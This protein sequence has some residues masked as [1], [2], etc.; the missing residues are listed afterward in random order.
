[1]R[2]HSAFPGHLRQIGQTHPAEGKNRALQTTFPC[3]DYPFFVPPGEHIVYEG[4]P[5]PH[6]VCHLNG[7]IIFA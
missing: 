2:G 3:R 5:A 6:S 4:I 1:M 7:Q